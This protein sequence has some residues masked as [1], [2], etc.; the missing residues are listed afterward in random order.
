MKIR[1][2]FFTCS[3]AYVIAA[4]IIFIFSFGQRPWAWSRIEYTVRDLVNA[5]SLRQLFAFIW[6]P[7]E[8]YG[9]FYYLA[10]LVPWLVSVLV[11]VLLLNVSK[12]GAKR[13]RLF[14]GLSILAYYSVIVL[15]FWIQQVVYYWEYID[16][17]DVIKIWNIISRVMFLA[18]PLGGFGL[19]Y[20]A[21]TLVE[22]IGK[23]QFVD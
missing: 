19:G 17:S 16:W 22:W 18:W 11:L 3:L 20:L 2:A 8:M 7:G 15:A 21:A 10:I 13:R 1:Y 9:D 5:L 4:I 23:P 14:G 12:G 6:W